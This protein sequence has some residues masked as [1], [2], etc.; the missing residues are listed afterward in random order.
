MRTL[1]FADY[2]FKTVPS[3][4]CIGVFDGM[5]LGHQRIVDETVSLARDLEAQSVVIT[6]SVNP[7]MARQSAPDMPALQSR[8]DLEE[9]LA[10]RGVNYHCVIDFSSDMSKLSGEE[11]IALLCTSYE[12]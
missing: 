5:H 2:S 8:S 10:D 3:V 6:F 4:I 11:F 7:K 9:I 1:P 12:V